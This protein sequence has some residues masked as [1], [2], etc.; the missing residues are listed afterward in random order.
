MFC[1]CGVAT[2]PTIGDDADADGGRVCSGCAARK[3]LHDFGTTTLRQQQHL[4][5][6]VV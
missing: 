3:R 5:G 6:C 4:C 1:C 2:H